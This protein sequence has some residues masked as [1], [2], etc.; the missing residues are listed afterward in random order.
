VTVNTAAPIL[1]ARGPRRSFAAVRA[2]DR[3]D[4]D[5]EACEVVALIGDDGAGSQRW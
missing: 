2:L 1:E 4:F 5:V 3:P